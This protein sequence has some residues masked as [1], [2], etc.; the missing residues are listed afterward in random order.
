MP[1][2]NFR[3]IGDKQDKSLTDGSGI[4]E[5]YDIYASR[6][7]GKLKY[8][9]TLTITSNYDSVGSLVE[10]ERFG[11]TFTLNG[12]YTQETFTLSIASGTGYFRD[13]TGGSLAPTPDTATGSAVMAFDS[14][15]FTIASGN[16]ASGEGNSFTVRLTGSINGVVWER[17]INITAGTYSLSFNSSSYNEGSSTACTLTYSGAPPSEAI[18]YAFTPYTSL[19]G[20]VTS[21]DVSSTVTGSFTSS[22]SGS[23][24]QNINGPTLTSDFTTEGSETLQCRVSHYNLSST[25]N[26]FLAFANTTVNDTSLTPSASVSA[27][28]TSVNEGSSVNFVISMS[29]FSGGVVQWDTT[30]SADAEED[31][32]TP[33]SGSVT[34]PA[35]GTSGNIPITAVADGYTESGQTET[36][37]FRVLSPADNTTVLAT[38]QA[39]TINDTSTGSQE[40]GQFTE[41][42][43]RVSSTPSGL[44]YSPGQSTLLSAFNSTYGWQTGGNASG[45]T[46]ELYT[47]NTFTGDHLFECTVLFANNCS[48]PAIAIWSS[49]T[50]QWRWGT[51]SSRISLQ[52][53]CTTPYIYGTSSQQSAGSSTPTNSSNPI[54]LHLHHQPSLSRTR[55]W[56]TTNADDWGNE[57][58]NR[59][60]NIMSI[61]NNYGTNTGVYCGLSSDYDGASLGSTST[62]FT[63]WRITPG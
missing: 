23:G 16:S 34:L 27:S 58:S 53:N 56:V 3:Y 19:G 61:S 25:N 2:R 26:Y 18:F 11:V 20:S 28:T 36:F 54:T 40:P 1:V 60:G 7:G 9:H 5:L 13:S 45:S 55:A 31:D 35:N 32:I 51:Q 42:D 49:G 6:T 12:Y 17:T 50:P 37:Q 33:N 62:N 43:L 30:L 52:Q 4:A 21:A 10:G 8:P 47:S 15:M 29:N 48:D 46:Y 44:T 39:I 14:T 24:T 59:V 41:W 57:S 38:S 63:K 22:V